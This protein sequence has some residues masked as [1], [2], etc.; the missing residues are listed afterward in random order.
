VR[1]SKVDN[2]AHVSLC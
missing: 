2:S 1:F